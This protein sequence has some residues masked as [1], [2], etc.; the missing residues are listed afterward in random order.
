MERW[1]PVRVKSTLA[2]L[3]P[4]ELA[5]GEQTEGAVFL[6]WK[7]RFEADTK[8]VMEE[9]E[10]GWPEIEKRY[11]PDPNEPEPVDTYEDVM[12]LGPVAGRVST[13]MLDLLSST[14]A[15]LNHDDAP[16]GVPGYTNKRKLKQRS[17]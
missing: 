10:G 7:E 1:K 17:Q 15:R 5:S 9:P 6:R 8:W 16:S 2:P 12:G 4:V 13:I 3:L 11:G 14:T